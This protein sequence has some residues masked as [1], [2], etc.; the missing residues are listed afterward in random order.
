MSLRKQ[1]T[2]GLFWTFGQQ[3]GNQAI[4][5]IISIILARLLLPAE[6][7]L[8]GMVAVFIAIGRT[9]VDVGLTQSLIRNSE[10][11]QEDLSTVFFFN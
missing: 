5:F 11:D 6:F 8:I 9:L 7:G 1:A 3:F 2:S 10:T 4:S